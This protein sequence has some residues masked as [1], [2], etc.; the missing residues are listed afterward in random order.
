MVHCINVKYNVVASA[1]GGSNLMNLN[2][3]AA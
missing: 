2:R 3:K 1:A